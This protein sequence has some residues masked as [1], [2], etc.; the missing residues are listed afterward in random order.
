VFILKDIFRAKFTQVEEA[1]K[2]LLLTGNSELW[3]GAPRQPK[4]RMKNLE[5]IRKEIQQVI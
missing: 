5:E 2:I 1:R 3:H 4:H